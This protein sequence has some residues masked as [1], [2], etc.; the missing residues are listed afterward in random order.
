M[1][2]SSS[3]FVLPFLPVALA[4]YGGGSGSGTT[5]S[6]AAPPP[7]STAS[8]STPGVQTVMVGADNALAYS[9]NTLT[10]DPGSIIEFMFFPPVHTVVQSTF[11]SP[12]APFSNGTGFY[13]GEF[14][15][16]SGSNANVFAL[17][18]NNTDPIWFFCE[19]PGHCQAGMAGV[20][21]AP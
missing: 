7:A 16:S 13:S 12:C 10:A 8:S 19:V 3:Q 14:T 2:F 20:I 9:P 15:T 21:N 17:T 1:Y 11:D 6:A 18:I 5:S 4:Q